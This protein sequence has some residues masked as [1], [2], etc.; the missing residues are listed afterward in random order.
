M[1]AASHE[2]GHRNIIGDCGVRVVPG[3]MN[4]D[5]RRADRAE[6]RAAI[7]DE[8]AR[9][10]PVTHVPLPAREAAW[11]LRHLVDICRRAGRRSVP[12]T[13]QSFDDIQAAAVR[14]QCVACR[15]WFDV[16]VPRGWTRCRSCR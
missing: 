8:R 13:P 6:I 12:V 15:Q 9:A 1:A 2:S 3:V 10:T 4:I 14:L 7:A 11:A 16:T 5:R